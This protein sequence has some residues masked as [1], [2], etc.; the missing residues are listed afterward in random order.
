LVFY[1]Q[2]EESARMLE[3]LVLKAFSKVGGSKEG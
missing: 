3:E 2:T 1:P